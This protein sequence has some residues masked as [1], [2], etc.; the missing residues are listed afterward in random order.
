MKADFP[1]DNE[2]EPFRGMSN[3]PRGSC[4]QMLDHADDE[5][6]GRAC[7]MM[8]MMNLPLPS[9][10][11]LCTR[12]SCFFPPS[13]GGLGARVLETKDIWFRGSFWFELKVERDM[14]GR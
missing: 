7:M 12:V 2:L 13:N 9:M 5:C 10:V 4:T 6:F 8:M 1:F 3:A 14:I 11:V